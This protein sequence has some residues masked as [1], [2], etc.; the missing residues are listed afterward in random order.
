MKRKTLTWIFAIASFLWALFIFSNSMQTGEN[1]GEMSGSVTELI[2]GILGSVS[3]S[4]E[5]THRFVRKAAHFSEFAVLGILLCF[6]IYS[7]AKGKYQ[8]RELVCFFTVPIATVVAMCDEFIQL[9]VDGR[10]GSWID[11]LIDTSGASAAA[12][13]FFGITVLIKLYKEKRTKN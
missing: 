10:G 3:P 8:R 13:V 12:L 2:N 1:S 7:F 5:V 11:V 4:L 6:G 9:F